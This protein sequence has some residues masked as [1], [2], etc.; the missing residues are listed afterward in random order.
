MRKPTL[1]K[2]M[3]LVAACVVG[4]AASS[5]A[6]SHGGH[7]SHG[8]GGHSHGG[9][10]HGGGHSHGGGGGGFHAGKSHNSG[11]GHFGGTNRHG[12]FSGSQRHTSAASSHDVWIV[13]LPAIREFWI[14]PRR[15][16]EC[17]PDF[18]WT[19]EFGNLVWAQFEPGFELGK[20][21]EVCRFV[22]SEP[23][24]KFSART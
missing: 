14:W 12:G 9:G 22:W 15:R 21:V 23:A 2:S 24:A 3:L 4:G 8:G 17:Q 5:A 18:R 19:A 7:G 20:H 16:V 6:A 10:S 13:F 11:G 1:L